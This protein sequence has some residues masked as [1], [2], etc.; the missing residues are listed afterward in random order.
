[1]G[2]IVVSVR[3]L[4]DVAV[5]VRRVEAPG[6]L[7]DVRV[8]EA[9]EHDVVDSDRRRPGPAVSGDAAALGGNDEPVGQLGG[10]ETVGG[11]LARGTWGVPGADSS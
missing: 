8:E 9:A 11:A 7:L 2:D 10:G 3:V 1:M 6:T 4:G 5:G